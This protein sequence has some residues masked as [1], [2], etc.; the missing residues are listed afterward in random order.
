M[1]IDNHRLTDDPRVQPF[2][3]TPNFHNPPFKTSTGLPDAVIIHYTAM[4]TAAGAVKV[5]T[6][7]YEKR[8]IPKMNQN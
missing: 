5:L 6:T 7:K 8:L 2:Q 3:Q 1:K 4:T